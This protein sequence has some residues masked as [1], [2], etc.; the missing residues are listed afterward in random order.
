MILCRLQSLM[1]ALTI[2]VAK[3]L[4]L[5][6]VAFLANQK[7]LLPF[8]VSGVRSNYLG[9]VVDHLEGVRTNGF[10]LL[11]ILVLCSV[12]PSDC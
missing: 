3:L 7:S 12:L 10:I 11:L 1:R 5:I 8:S 4:L 9:L 2:V 6:L